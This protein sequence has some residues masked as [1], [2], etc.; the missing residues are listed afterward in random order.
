MLPYYSIIDTDQEGK[1]LVLKTRAFHGGFDP[2]RGAIHSPSGKAFRLQEIRRDGDFHYLIIRGLARRDI[3]SMDRVIPADWGAA[4]SKRVW[5]YSPKGQYL[6]EELGRVDDPLAASSRMIRGE[7]QQKD[8]LV[9][10]RC[11]KPQLWV[12]GL[13]Y[14]I[15]GYH[16]PLLLLFHEDL[17]KSQL[18]FVQKSLWDWKREQR[19]FR[20]VT[21]LRLALLKQTAL[22]KEMEEI[23]L[24]ECRRGRGYIIKEDHWQKRS[25][26]LLKALSRMGGQREKDLQEEYGILLQP[27]LQDWMD[28]GTIEL[29]KGYYQR[30]DRDPRSSLSPFSA[31]LL[32][33]LESSDLGLNPAKCKPQELEQYILMDRMGLLRCG[34]QWI[35]SEECYKMNSQVVKDKLKNQAPMELADIKEAVE[36]SRRELL[37]LLQWMEEEGEIQNRD[38]LRSLT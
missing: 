16:K 27:L 12:P 15:Q 5:L 7:I 24:P 18:G 20:Q 36:L 22:P 35:C 37:T 21:A 6:Q 38:Q 1:Q 17:N 29:R 34:D 31:S 19:E 13:E 32:A 23:N 30:S 8:H 9:E 28:Q 33:R 26:S 2:E 4:R 3:R 11:N 14:G 10:L 25:Q